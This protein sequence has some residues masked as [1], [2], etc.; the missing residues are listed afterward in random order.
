MANV[1]AKN[2][3]E[4]FKKLLMKT[5]VVLDKKLRAK[6]E[7]QPLKKKIIKD[8]LFQKELDLFLQHHYYNP[9]S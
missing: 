3:L 6:T 5:Q 4:N 7:K 1:D 2:V 8:I 9:W